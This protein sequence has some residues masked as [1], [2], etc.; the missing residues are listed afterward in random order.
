M[1]D[2]INILDEESLTLNTFASRNPHYYRNLINLIKN[3]LPVTMR[4]DKKLEQVTFPKSVAKQLE[5]IWNPSGADK[6][7]T[8]TPE[9]V[10]TMKR[11]PLIDTNGLKWSLSNVEKNED[12]KKLIGARGEQRE[13][14]WWNKG[15]V[16]E[17][18]MSAAVITKFENPDQ[19]ITG[20]DVM[21]T[22]KKVQSNTY[23]TRALKRRLILKIVL[24]ANDYRALIMSAQEPDKFQV[25]EKS[26]EIYKLYNDTATYVNSSNNVQS[27][28]EKIQ[29]SAPKD[30]I[31]VTAD[32]ATAEAQHS[33]KADLW[34]AVNGKK[35]RL[36]SIKTATVKH[37][38]AVSG[39]EFKHLN[40]FF[41]STVNVEL[42]AE[43][44]KYFKSMP[45]SLPKGWKKGDPIPA[46]YVSMSR[47]ERAKMLT[48]LREENFA[49]GTKRAYQYVFN[50]ISKELAGTSN[51]SEYDFIKE[52][53]N[54]VIHHATLGEDI[55]IVIISPSAKKAYTELQFG[56]ELHKALENYD[57][58]PVLNVDGANF[59]LLVYGYPKGIAN[60]VNNDKSLFVQLRS[61]IQDTATRNVVE[62][63]GLL[64]DLTDV[65][66]LQKAQVTPTTQFKPQA[67]PV[68]AKP[69]T[70]QSITKPTSTRI[71]EPVQPPEE[72]PANE[73]PPKVYGNEKTL[74][75]KRQR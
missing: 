40:A 1:R 55:R 62:I 15:N 4:K 74:G 27:A 71:Q 10:A 13:S 36:L 21:N 3:G 22:L 43:Y 14:K 25:F 38:G 37:V 26:A 54:G 31:E 42:P 11:F 63:G 72:I 32:G 49:N 33:T 70:K 61:Y 75:R 52:V 64:K 50:Q 65:E 29:A 39:Y 34:I 20:Q 69:A 12:I 7:E 58:I 24:S 47:D 8:A 56:P 28:I 68:V 67:K 51:T 46:G 18:I 35:E 30:V 45:P 66:K 17:G 60:R 59:K 48:N 44:Q 23:E 6:T 9:Q 53:T 19:A 2:L 41:K 16:A 73:E 57:L 5:Q